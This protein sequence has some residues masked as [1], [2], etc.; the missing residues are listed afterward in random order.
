MT[1]ALIRGYTCCLVRNCDTV[2]QSEG[3]LVAC[4]TPTRHSDVSLECKISWLPA[5]D[6]AQHFH[7]SESGSSCGPALD[8]ERVGGVIKLS[9]DYSRQRAIPRNLI[10]NS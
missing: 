6:G 3:F 8:E 10:L 1:S 7:P 2:P 5:S 9:R 4:T